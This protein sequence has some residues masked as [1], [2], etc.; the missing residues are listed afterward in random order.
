[1]CRDIHGQEGFFVK[2]RRR[3][4]LT[5]AL[6]AAIPALALAAARTHAHIYRPFSAAGKP[7]GH[8]T[9]MFPGSCIGGSD[10]SRRSDAWRCLISG[11]T[12]ADPCFSSAKAKSFVLCPA[13]GPWSSNVIK[14]KL[15]QKLPKG[16]ANKGKPSMH[17]LPWALVTVRGWK[18]RLDT[19]AT[20]VAHGKR[21]NYFCKGTSKSLWGSPQRGSEP[22]KIYVAGNH[23]KHFRTRTGI[24]AAWF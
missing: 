17:G 4:A 14:V 3:V 11:S 10:A 12:I 6:L 22:W 13:S 5:A 8:V 18:C 7:V 2:L 21:Q 20:S 24:K 15:V 16:K 9:H 23:P 1:V 19:G